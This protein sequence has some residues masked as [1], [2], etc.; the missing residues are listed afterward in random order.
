MR[1][2]PRRRKTTF[3]PEVRELVRETSQVLTPRIC[4]APAPHQ[5]TQIRIVSTN[6]ME[7]C[8]RQHDTSLS[9]DDAGRSEERPASV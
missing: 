1:P 4:V 9:R 6:G 3:T 7:V 5:D 8:L 2:T